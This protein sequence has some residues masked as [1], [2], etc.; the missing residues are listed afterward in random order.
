MMKGD[1]QK[2]TVR[3]TDG[4]IK[5]KKPLIKKVERSGTEASYRCIRCRG[6]PVCKKVLKLNL[7]VYKKKFSKAL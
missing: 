1:S 4:S 7:L 3:K 6:C 2:K 5:Y